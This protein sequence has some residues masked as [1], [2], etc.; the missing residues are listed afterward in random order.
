LGIILE[1]IVAKII[2]PS[3]KQQGIIT[4]SINQMC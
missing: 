1:N 2:V 4:L 3:S